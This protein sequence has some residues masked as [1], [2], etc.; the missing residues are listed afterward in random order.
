MQLDFNLPNHLSKNGRDLLARLLTNS[1]DRRASIQEV[2][3]HPWY[4]QGLPLSALEMNKVYLTTRP[5]NNSQSLEECG[6]IV[7]KAMRHPDDLRATTTPEDS[8][9]DLIQQALAEEEEGAEY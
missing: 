9:E 5:D 6:R 2:M 3:H 8:T 1:P 4:L 7:E